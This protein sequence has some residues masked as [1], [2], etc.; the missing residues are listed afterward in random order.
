MSKITL[1]RSSF[2]SLLD[3]LS[4]IKDDHNDI[5]IR[6]GEMR[7]LSLNRVYIFEADLTTILGNNDLVLPMVK[8]KVS[9]LNVLSND[10]IDLLVEPNYYV[11]TDGISD[12]RFNKSSSDY[13]DNKYMSNQEMSQYFVLDDSLIS[14]SI[15]ID[16]GMQN[17]IKVFSDNF[18]VDDLMININ[19][20]SK[21]ELQIMSFSNVGDAKIVKDIHVNNITEKSRICISVKPFVLDYK[22][23]VDM[24]V[25]RTTDEN[26]IVKLS[27]SINNIPFQVYILG[28]LEKL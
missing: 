25:Y 16:K 21:A 14:F 17:K 2:Q 5:D 18:N 7:Q 15:K 20:N 26:V 6:N 8:S 28:Y 19:E 11:F 13:L 24:I 22:N 9:L 4:L 27:S 23:D 1:D 3:I 10:T 12:L